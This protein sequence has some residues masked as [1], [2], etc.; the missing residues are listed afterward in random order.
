LPANVTP[1]YEVGSLL[2][3]AALLGIEMRPDSGKM[4]TEQ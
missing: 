4:D 1:D 2:E 3:A